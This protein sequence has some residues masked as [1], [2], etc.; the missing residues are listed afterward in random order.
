MADKD[1][2][3][4][5]GLRAEPVTVPLL[6]DVTQGLRVIQRLVVLVEQD[7]DGS[8]V[9]SDDLFLM[10]G[11][12]E[13]REAALDDYV[14]SLIEYYDILD[15]DAASGDPMSAAQFRHLREYVHRLTS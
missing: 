14:T 5:V 2:Q 15:T 13:T 12:G 6:G 8:Y 7:D 11:N 10:Y 9:V 4:G 1:T 3:E